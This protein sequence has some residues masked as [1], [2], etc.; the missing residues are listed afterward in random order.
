VTAVRDSTS[1]NVTLTVKTNAELALSSLDLKPVFNSTYYSLNATIG[2]GIAVGSNMATRN[3][4]MSNTIGTGES[5]G[6]VQFT[7]S[8]SSG[9]STL[10]SGDTI[11]TYTFTPNNPVDGDYDFSVFISSA[12]R[13]AGD[14]FA[15][16]WDWVGASG[17]TLDGATI[18]IGCDHSNRTEHTYNAATCTADGNIAYWSCDDCDKL[19]DAAT[20]GNEVTNVTLA[21]LGHEYVGGTCTRCNQKQP[22]FTAYYRLYDA[23]GNELTADADEL[24]GLDVEA[25]KTY[26]AKVYLASGSGDSQEITNF[27]LNLTY[28]DGITFVANGSGKAD[29]CDTTTSGKIRYQMY[30][31]TDTGNVL[32][33][34]T[35]GIL[36]AQF[37]FTVGDVGMGAAMALGFDA[38]SVGTSANLTKN[39]DV[40]TTNQA[41]GT[42]KTVTVTWDL[43]GGNVDGNTTNPT[44]SITYNS[45]ATAPTQTVTRDG[46]TF[47]GWTAK[48][49]TGDAITTFSALT[50]DTTYYAKWS[51]NTYTITYDLD[52]GTLSGLTGTTEDYTIEANKILGTPTRVGYTFSGW[53]IEE[54]S[55]DVTNLDETTTA[56]ETLSLVG[57]Y[58]SISV[59]AHWT[60]N[61]V[62]KAVDY[63][64]APS[65][66]SL[67]IVSAKPDSNKT[68]T[69]NGEK[70]YYVAGTS[71]DNIYYKKLASID[72]VTPVSGAT[73]VYVT[74]LD[75]AYDSTKLQLTEG[76][77]MA[78]PTITNQYD[79]NQDN[80][81]DA[82][83]ASAAYQL[84]MKRSSYSLTQASVLVRL[85]ADVNHDFAATIDDASTIARNFTMNNSSTNNSGT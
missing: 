63:T 44:E 37:T 79:L 1:G 9:N 49:D 27:I 53:T 77:D 17:V 32:S 68:M 38:S 54:V 13:E 57:K 30:A 45:A 78:F 51:L 15:T 73:G 6:L 34:P 19:F 23:N 67:L 10:L 4:D 76:K 61:I 80:V 43:N 14:E 84:L 31:P 3:F 62:A 82:T 41:I 50:D 16:S 11:V 56:A 81:V 2:N 55:S 21:A 52:N 39:I 28:T 5:F 60:F 7:S 42:L 59:K 83:D 69:Y 8:D 12:A 36:V 74:V 24:N 65:N 85:L 33:V 72:G 18:T 64:Y 29:S 46:Y 48:K 70:M 71:D 25:N 35:N 58:G 66:G 20:G 26:T 40:T 47:K 75:A 22:A